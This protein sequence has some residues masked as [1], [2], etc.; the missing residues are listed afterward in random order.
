MSRKNIFEILD[1]EIDF[2]EEARRIY[3]LFS[4]KETQV[5]CRD[6]QVHTLSLEEFINEE[7]F[8]TWRHRGRCISVEE[9]KRKIGINFNH[10][11]LLNDC[12]MAL[13]LNYCE[14]VSN[15]LLLFG[16]EETENYNAHKFGI[17]NIG[18]TGGLIIA[19]IDS[20]LNELNMKRSI[21]NDNLICRIVEINPS[22]TMA[23]DNLEK[24]AATKVFE[25][26]HYL[27]KGDL[28]KKREILI[29][30][31]GLVEPLSKQ[32]NANGYGSIDKYTRFLL[33]NMNIRHNNLEGKE[34]NPFLDSLG[35]DELEKIYDK[36]YE[37]ILLCVNLSS[38]IDDKQFLDGLKQSKI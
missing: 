2:G 12:T 17:M 33:N 3:A 19:N 29:Y 36:T 14:Y 37:L 6:N 18:I 1:K 27:L 21:D 34:K 22:A 23:A 11:N 24:E 31:S 25:Y 26:N 9:F 4:E 20:C 15:M 7:Y 28:A 35:E 16:N 30:L 32:L 13:F 5:T 8:S 38:Y 10:S